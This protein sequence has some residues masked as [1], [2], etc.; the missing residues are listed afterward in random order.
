MPLALYYLGFLE[1]VV[2]VSTKMPYKENVPRISHCIH[3]IVHGRLN[4]ISSASKSSAEIND[5]VVPSHPGGVWLLQ[6]N[7]VISAGVVKSTEPAANA[8]LCR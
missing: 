5:W 7:L 3:L 6:S 2:G 4:S 1:A 8:S